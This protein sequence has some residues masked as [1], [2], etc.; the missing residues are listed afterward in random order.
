MLALGDFAGLTEQ[1]I[2]KSIAG[3]YAP[4]H[5]RSNILKATSSECPTGLT[6]ML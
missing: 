1:Q 3:G 2:K 5:R 6:R 4:S